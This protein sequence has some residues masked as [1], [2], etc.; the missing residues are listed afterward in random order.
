MKLLKLYY[1]TG[2]ATDEIA[3]WSQK[4]FGYF[5]LEKNSDYDDYDII[6]LDALGATRGFESS[7]YF[8]IK[9]LGVIRR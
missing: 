5:Q 3:I 2:D 4:Q 1:A 8:R 9:I 6:T 7:G